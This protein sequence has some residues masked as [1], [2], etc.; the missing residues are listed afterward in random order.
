MPREFASVNLEIWSD[1]DFRA[2][3]PAAQ[4]LY[5]LLWTSPSLSY[6]GVHDWRPGRMTGLS[7]GFTPEH[8]QT[9]ADCLTARHFLVIDHDTEEVLV[10]SW[11]RWDGLMKQP[12]MAV[13]Y[14][15]AYASVASQTL[16]AVLA[17][18]TKK[19]RSQL[20]N[21]S[22]WA[23]ERVAQIL[24]H[25]A[26][27]AK[28]LP[29]PSDPFGDDFGGGFGLGLPQ[30]PGGVW[31]SVWTPP[32]PAPTPTPN[33]SAPNDGDK[34]PSSKRATQLAD[35]W[36]PSDAHKLLA[37][38][39][40]VDAGEEAA[41]FRDY[42]TANGKTYKDWEAAFRNWLRNARPTGGPRAQ[43]PATHLPHAS[44][45]ESPPDGLSDEE[46]LDWHAEQQRKRAVR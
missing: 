28:T 27:S 32:T 10:R 45:I 24:T 11:A 17:H 2:L 22:C 36:Q 1:P 37:E 18:E 40:G 29:C 26:V 30:T 3:P 46:Y 19:I 35:D 20:P 5:L 12:R 31:G 33:T 44:E 6:C 41:K 4:H 15:T 7:R 14:S 9:V 16:R 25:P 38:E 23:D 43:R 34:S 13:T 39:R 8:V 21:L 42:C